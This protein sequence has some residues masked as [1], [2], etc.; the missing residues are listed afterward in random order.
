VTNDIDEIRLGVYEEGAATDEPGLGD[1]DPGG[2]SA[3][4]GEACLSYVAVVFGAC[5][6]GLGDGV[7]VFVWGGAWSRASRCF[8]GVMRGSGP[9]RASPRVRCGTGRVGRSARREV[10]AEAGSSDGG[11]V[12]AYD[13]GG[14]L[15]RERP[16]PVPR[17]IEHIAHYARDF[18]LLIRQTNSGICFSRA[19]AVASRLPETAPGRGSGEARADPRGGRRRGAGQRSR[20]DRPRRQPAASR[21]PGR[22]EGHKRRD[23]R[24]RSVGGA[25]REGGPKEHDSAARVQQYLRD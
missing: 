10:A 20:R 8:L 3:C 25:G 2:L 17:R 19:A 13:A 14:G 6:V 11:G 18:T 16:P 15:S 22:I 7:G 9:F 21:D 1:L 23:P 24:Y 4:V 5:G 12:D